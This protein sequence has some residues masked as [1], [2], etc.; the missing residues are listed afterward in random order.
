MMRCVRNIHALGDSR[1]GIE[2][3]RQTGMI[4]LRLRKVAPQL[5]IGVGARFELAP[6]GAAGLVID[7]SGNQKLFV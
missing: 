6:F 5:R 3:V 2:H 4:A 7:D 1:G